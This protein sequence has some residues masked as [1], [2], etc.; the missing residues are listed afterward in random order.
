VDTPER[1][2]S[3][4]GADFAK[5]QLQGRPRV[6]H[7]GRPTSQVPGRLTEIGFDVATASEQ[8]LEKLDA[9]FDA[10][11]FSHAL[12]MVGS[13]ESTIDQAARLLAPTGRLVVDDVDVQATDT[14]SL[15]W[16]Y[17]VQ[18]LLAVAGLYPKDRVHAPH[19]DPIARWREGVKAEGLVRTGTE[20]RVAVSARFAIRDLKRV[21]YLYR[22][23]SDGL[24]ADAKG[25][26]IASHLRTVERRLIATDTL[27]PV[28][29]RIVADRAR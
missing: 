9:A 4:Q 14:T 1:I 23:I 7:V 28:G 25:A 2:R 13:L 3:E 11:V 10:I 27:L 22:Y 29:L 18:E 19:A 26:A 17:D 6:L 8:D 21:E 20:I 12:S 5:D 15:R 16:F 24:S